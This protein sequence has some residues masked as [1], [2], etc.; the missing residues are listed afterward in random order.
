MIHK[1]VIPAK[2]GIQWIC[3]KSI[4]NNVND[5]GYW[6]PAFAGTTMP[7]LPNCVSP[8][9]MAGQV[10]HSGERPNRPHLAGCDYHCTYI[11]MTTCTYRSE[12]AGRNTP[13]LEELVTSMATL[14]RPSTFTM[15]WR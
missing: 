9:K 6:V 13:G 3:G 12:S 7:N 8:I 11:G 5:F 15:S 2:A 14:P 4:R 1:P 10:L